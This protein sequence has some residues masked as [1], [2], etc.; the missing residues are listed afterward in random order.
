MKVVMGQTHAD[1]PGTLRTE[2]PG[3]T[4][5]VATTPADQVRA[6]VDADAFYG[7]PTRE[8]FLAA[9]RLR[10]IHEPG[11]GIDKYQA[12]PELAESDVVLTNARGPHVVPMAD[13]AFAL[14][15][16]LTH[17]V[18]EL[19]EDKRARRWD[20]SRYGGRY[21][22]LDG[23]TMGI[24]ALGDIGLAVAR[25]AVGFGMRVRA[26]EAAPMPAPAG[27]EAVWGPEGLDELL[28]LSDVFV[29]TAPLTART[30]RLIDHRRLALLPR[31]AFVIVVSRGG[32]VDEEALADGL[33][34]GRIAGAGLDVTSQEPLPP[35]SPLWDLDNV[36][37]SPHSSASSPEVWPGRRRIFEENL[38]RFLAGEPFLYVCDKKAGY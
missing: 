13:H 4:F 32:I 31:G 8:A 3:V 37:I 23:K 24:L 12:I 35:E 18:S 36:L 34:S 22:D 29:V 5:E 6:I 17:R 25:R 2:F 20:G 30:R 10:W 1:L 21:V 33:R 38:R 26:V 11:T 28:S 7:P 14:L 15:L 16:A 9:R 27:V 19:V